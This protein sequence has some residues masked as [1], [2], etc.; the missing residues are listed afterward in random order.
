MSDFDDLISKGRS[1]FGASTGAGAGFGGGFGDD[2][3]IDTS[4]PFA[5][6]QSSTLAFGGGSSDV[7]FPTSSFSSRPETSLAPRSPTAVVPSF[8]VDHDEPSFRNE[9]EAAHHEPAYVPEPAPAEPEDDGYGFDPDAGVASYVPAPTSPTNAF[10]IPGPSREADPEGRPDY[11]EDEGGFGAPMRLPS[12]PPG[13]GVDFSARQRREGS[14]DRGFAESP[15]RSTAAVAPARRMTNEDARH[16]E[17]FYTH[18][19][20]PVAPAAA[21]PSSSSSGFRDSLPPSSQTQRQLPAAGAPPPATA[22]E[23]V[24]RPFG[25]TATLSSRRRGSESSTSDDDPLSPS[26]LDALSPGSGSG[27]KALP[28]FLGGPF[29]ASMTDSFMR[30]SKSLP[31]F[32]ASPKK[33]RKSTIPSSEAPKAGDKADKAAEGK[34]DKDAKPVSHSRSGSATA[35]KPYR[36]FGLKRAEPKPVVPKEPPPAPSAA[37]AANGSRRSSATT[38]APPPASAPSAAPAA[39]AAPDAPV[40][41]AAPA[42]APSAA[43]ETTVSAPPTSAASP[44]SVAEAAPTEPEPTVAPTQP[45]QDA[46]SSPS[47]GP[48]TAA[49]PTPAPSSHP[50]SVLSSRPSSTSIVTVSSTTAM[51]APQSPRSVSSVSLSAASRRTADEVAEPAPAAGVAQAVEEEAFDVKASATSASAAPDAAVA[52]EIGEAP[53]KAEDEPPASAAPISEREDQPTPTAATSSG[54]KQDESDEDERPLASVRDDLIAAASASN[55][56]VNSPVVG[57]PASLAPAGAFV[58]VAVPGATSAVGEAPAPAPRFI[59]VVGDPQK[60]GSIND[61]HTVYTVRTKVCGHS[62][63]RRSNFADGSSTRLRRLPIPRLV[64]RSKARA[65][66]CGGLEISS[67]SPKHWS[68]TILGSSSLRSRTRTFEV[69]GPAAPSLQPLTVNHAGRFQPNFISARRVALEIFLQ[70]TTNHPMLVSDPDLKMFLES[71]SFSLEIKHRKPDPAQQQGWLSNLG[72]PR[73]MEFDDFYDNRRSSVDALEHQLRAL[74]VSLHTAAKSRL[75][76]ARSL[77]ELSA[78][79]IALSECDLSRPM[80]N[81][82]EKLAA[83]HKQLNIWAEE[84]AREEEEGL[85]ATVDAYARLCASVRA[86]FGG[87]VRSWEKWKLSEQHLRKVQQGWEKVKRSSVGPGA[88]GVTLA[89]LSDVRAKLSSRCNHVQ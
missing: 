84:E 3:G 4:N 87:R 25:V 88:G 78:S 5:D 75:T 19:E 29:T 18:R 44:T 55:S 10:L 24:F 79:L 42:A 13:V 89:D 1:A 14:L 30:G 61:I 35:A 16:P 77:S 49:T 71:D 36:P 38:T 85:G 62:E 26:A 21:P 45:S 73:F 12:P 86:T 56:V 32:K 51:I 15:P 17:G 59:C 22:E 57:T 65:P 69:R 64:G 7:S 81:A 82:L 58:P 47:T 80:R 76:L 11:R 34:A 8:G 23:P 46:T 53:A 31:A 66:C 28:D 33:A 43:P 70:K 52:A 37:S 9:Y 67:G 2:D 20:Q 6:L 60:M 40:T 39:P 48:A 74:H 83:L 68:I 54:R 50:P 63:S 72:G 27:R 41:T